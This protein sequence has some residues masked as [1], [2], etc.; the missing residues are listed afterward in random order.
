MPVNITDYAARRM[1]KALNFAVTLFFIRPWPTAAIKTTC[2]SHNFQRGQKVRNL[3][4]IF[5]HARL[6]AAL[7]SKCSKISE[8]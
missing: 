5:S 2:L 6:W 7:I 8:I 3:P 4:S 1:S